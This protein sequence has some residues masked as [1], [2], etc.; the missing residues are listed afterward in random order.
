MVG[1]GGKVDDCE[2][3]EYDGAETPG[4]AENVGIVG[5]GAK[6]VGCDTIGG[7]LTEY[8]I[9]GG[10]TGREPEDGTTFEL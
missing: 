4:C 5:S 9:G 3:L 10:A 8:G 2:A 1:S 7:D 6:V